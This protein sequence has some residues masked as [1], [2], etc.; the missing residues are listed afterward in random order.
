M[1]NKSWGPFVDCL[2]S[3]EIQERGIGYVVIARR[4]SSQTIRC[5]AFV[6]DA[7][8]LGVKDCFFH[9]CSAMDYQLIIGSLQG[10]SRLI[11]VAPAYQ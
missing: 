10:A 3:A 9:K 2:M 4:K 1:S 6:V 7:F 11:T 5:I 8:C